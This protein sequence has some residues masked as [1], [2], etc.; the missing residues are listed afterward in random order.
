MTQTHTHTQFGQ[1]ALIWA[2]EKGRADCVRLLIDA[3]AD[4]NATAKVRASRFGRVCGLWR[5]QCR[6]LCQICGSVQF[7]F[8]FL[9][10]FCILNF[11]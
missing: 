6:F 11:N 2:A 5:V 10:L 9:F 3:G 8:L 1:T 7:A 4:T